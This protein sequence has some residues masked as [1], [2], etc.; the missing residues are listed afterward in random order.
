MAW[1]F[2]S[3]GWLTS[4]W[5]IGNDLNGHMRFPSWFISAGPFWKAK[6]KFC[7]ASEEQSSWVHILRC[8]WSQSWRLEW[9]LQRKTR[10]IECVSLLVLMV[11]LLWDQKHVCIGTTKRIMLLHIPFE[12]IKRNQRWLVCI[13]NPLIESLIGRRIAHNP[14]KRDLWPKQQHVH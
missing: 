4:C 12:S 13:I 6:E 10:L 14:T 2:F 3:N 7:E 5:W 8:L 11:T 1:L 9:S